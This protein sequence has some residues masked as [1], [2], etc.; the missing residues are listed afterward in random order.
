[1][2]TPRLYADLA[3]WYRMVDPVSDHSEEADAYRAA[4]TRAVAGRSETLLE[5]GSGAGHNAFYL[6]NGFRCT[7]TDLSPDM[8]ALNRALNPECEHLA[9]DM[10]TLRLGRV[11]DAVLLHD[12]VVYMTTEEDLL[13]AARTAFA[14]TRP[15]GAAIF[16]PD[17]LSESFR[18]STHV[19]EG[20]DGPRALRA[21]EWTWDPD[22]TDTTYAV[23]YAFLLRDGADVTAAHDRHQEGLFPE[24]T[25]HR[26]LRTAGFD[27]ETIERPVGGGEVDRIFLCRRA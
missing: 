17:L 25:W 23:E 3:S 26:L 19:I 9:G 12:A 18:E 20:A 11:F 22:P 15:G 13:A 10:R 27:A 1:M 2:P 6:K 4:L 5:L 16:A 21:L 14:H 7:L 24:A 8:L